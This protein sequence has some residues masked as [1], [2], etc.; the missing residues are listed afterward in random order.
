M[1]EYNLKSLFRM[2]VLHE[3]MQKTNPY[4]PEEVSLAKAAIISFI[5]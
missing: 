5:Q 2:F 4:T 1:I 3:K